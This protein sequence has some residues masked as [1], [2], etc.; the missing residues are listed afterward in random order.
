MK[1]MMQKSD[2]VCFS[3]TCYTSVMDCVVDTILFGG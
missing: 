3:E 1:K 2:V